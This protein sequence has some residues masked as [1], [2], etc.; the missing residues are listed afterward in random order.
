[1]ERVILSEAETAALAAQYDENAKR[2]LFNR[3]ILAAK[4]LMEVALKN[5]GLANK[6]LAKFESQI[7][8][9]ADKWDR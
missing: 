2:I 5:E 9:L 6:D 8:N 7:Q 4:R 3:V 1:M